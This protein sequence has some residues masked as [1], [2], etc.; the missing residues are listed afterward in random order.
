MIKN[1]Q[2]GQIL[3][4]GVTV[5]DLLLQIGQLIDAKISV[6]PVNENKQSDYLSRKE[7]A[8]LL[9][10]TLPTLHDWTKLGYLK[11]YKIGTRVLYKQCEVIETLENVPS[12]K[13]KKG[14]YNGI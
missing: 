13:H 4:T 10:I 9:K 2:M 3:F 12:F 11:S 6:I 8:K 1:N 14:V 5:N 7:V